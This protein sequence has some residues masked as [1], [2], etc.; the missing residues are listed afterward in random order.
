MLLYYMSPRHRQIMIP[1]SVLDL[2]PIVHGATAGDAFRNSRDLAQR[3]ERLGFKRYW[4]AEH[5]NMSGIASAAT[6]VVIGHVAAGTTTIRLGAGGVMLP[7]HSPLVVAE[8]FGT[9]ESL[10]P[11]RIDLGIGRAP[12]TDAVAAR[13]LRRDLHTSTD[14]FP[15][16]VVELL[17][18][19][20]P[21]KAG[22]LVRAVPGAGLR[23]P[24]WLL[25]SSLYSAQL[26]AALGLPFAFASHFAPDALVQALDIYRAR[27]QPS[28]RLRQPYAMPGV[29]VVAADTDAEA[30]R[31]FTSM[32]QQFVN[33]RRGMPGQLQ[34]PLDDIE[35]YWTPS[36]KAG[37][38]HALA[39]A[40]VGSRDTVRDKLRSFIAM[41]KAD[42]LMVTAHIHDHGA[43]V[44]SYEIV[45][46]VR[47]ELGSSERPAS[48]A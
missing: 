16:D 23:V 17:S 1:F 40:V 42:E 39:Y 33:L 29:N 47:D 4:L 8:Q 41:T 44:R 37:V 27:F 2:A 24:V 25:G 18:Y 38:E 14:T 46:S 10:F 9:L 28:D 43:R 15:H 45:A 3:A 31:L 32:Q 22:Q 30:K 21:V 34:P 36:E 48:A 35:Q 12:G 6:A 26:A 11:G 19:F 5:H 13:A 20:E 7:N